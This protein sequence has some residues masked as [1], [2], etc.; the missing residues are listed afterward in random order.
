[1]GKKIDYKIEK[2]KF[3]Q[4]EVQSALKNLKPMQAYTLTKKENADIYDEVTK[5]ISKNYA[6]KKEVQF[7]D[8][9][10][11]GDTAGNVI[12]SI[13][14][15]RID[16]DLSGNPT[17]DIDVFNIAPDSDK[18]NTYFSSQFFHYKKEDGDRLTFKF[19]DGHL[20]NLDD[21][22]DELYNSYIIPTFTGTT[23]EEYKCQRDQLFEAFRNSFSFIIK[24]K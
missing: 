9:I 24:L 15:G 23:F 10:Y 18:T 14:C 12:L 16:E 5:L 19:F 13:I 17:C 8:I 7:A 1:M 2:Q 21:K 22:V 11:S 20:S 4:A 6:Q 3:R